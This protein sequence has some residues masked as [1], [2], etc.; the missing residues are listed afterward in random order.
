MPNFYR[1]THG[2]TYIVNGGGNLFDD[3]D[4]QILLNE[5]VITVAGASATTLKNMNK[6]DY[7]YLLHGNI[8]NGNPLHGIQLI[9]RITDDVASTYN[10]Q[11]RTANQYW[12]QRDY[13]IIAK[14]L[15]P[16][17]SKINR[18]G[19]GG[20]QQ[21]IAKVYDFNKLNREILHKYFNLHWDGTNVVPF[22]RNDD[23]AESEIAEP[24]IIS[25]PKVHL[26]TILYGPPGTGKTYLTAAYAV[27]ICAPKFMEDFG[28]T[29]EKDL[30]TRSFASYEYE[31]IFGYYKD[32]LDDGKV[33]FTTFHQS[34]GY[35]EFIEGIKPKMDSN[36]IEYEI[37]AG[38][39]K[40]FCD[41]A[42]DSE[43]NFVF[44]IDEINRGNISKIF[45][46]LIT[47]IEENK[48]LGNDEETT[49]Q[50]PYSKNFF[51]V[52]KNVYILGTMNTADR[53]IAIMDTA[54]RRRFHFVEMM[55]RP[56]ILSSDVAGVNLIEMLET[57]NQ[58]IEY[59][60]DREH[61]IGHAYFCGVDNISQL[62]DVFKNKII[63]LLQEYFFEDY[64][65]I[66]LVLGDN[67]FIIR[68][69]LQGIFKGD[70]ADFDFSEERYTYKIIDNAFNNAD[71]YKKIYE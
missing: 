61:T 58:R 8:A 35:E 37:A 70:T 12:V 56:K 25:L 65:K 4:L 51:G 14:A 68:E 40:N 19:I 71:N 50:L 7:F 69:K 48:R 13:E 23:V 45:G 41:K 49:A 55:P 59:L 47:L 46:E 34:Y 30:S 22:K 29:S 42:K 21:T 27:Y 9:G 36:N 24:K 16:Q 33:A 15:M 10:G 53:S 64:E 31:K 5:Q 6:G 32:L 18:A 26:N 67:G 28:V 39:F 2:L 17:T 63:P 3:N 54:L 62:A 66:R 44:I 57:M 52:P 20:G 1:V 43:E 60:Y 11:V 38:V